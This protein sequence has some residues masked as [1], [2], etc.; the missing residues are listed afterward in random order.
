MK[1]GEFDLLLAEIEHMSL[2][3]LRTVWSDHLGT[4]APTN[5]APLLR[6]GLAFELQAK[7]F[8]GLSKSTER[9]LRRLAEGEVDRPRAGMRFVREWSG[10]VHVVTIGDN[11]AVHWNDKDW[12]SLS[13]VARAITGT[14]WSG[15][16]FF[17]LKKKRSAA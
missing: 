6:L 9:R 4:V 11:G 12:K 16:A 1:Q 13:A 3:Q 5:S 7:R 15:P 10:K 14:R 2:A 8:G 17:G